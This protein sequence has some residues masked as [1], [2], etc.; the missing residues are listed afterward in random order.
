MNKF[1]TFF[2]A[3]FYKHPVLW[4]FFGIIVSM[5]VLFFI[6]LFFLDLWTH[7]GDETKVPNVVGMSLEKA[8]DELNAADLA[9]VISDSDYIKDKPA[10]T[11]IDIIPKPNSVV[12]AGREVYVTIVAYSS[13]PVQIDFN[14]LRGSF[15]QAEP[16]L[17]DLGIKYNVREVPGQYE[18]EIVGIKCRGKD[19]KLIDKLTVDDVLTIEVSRTALLHPVEVS[20]IDV[21][22]GSAI[23]NS[24]S[25]ESPEITVSEPLVTDDPDNSLFD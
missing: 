3:S 24:A 22:I 1:T 25:E 15:R 13:K 16:Y 9:V 12:K 14:R 20:P 5:A 19:I 4:S 7:H 2:K 11:I 23:E 18:D 21:M 6:T 8:T 10:G 17:K